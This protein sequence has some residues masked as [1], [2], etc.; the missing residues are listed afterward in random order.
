[1]AGLRSLNAQI[2]RLPLCAAVLKSEAESRT[3]WNS[4]R[5]MVEALMHGARREIDLA[6]DEHTVGDDDKPR[7]PARN[8]RAGQQI[9]P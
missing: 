2:H 8:S 3:D 1:V 6:V 7:T 9:E 4:R 5:P